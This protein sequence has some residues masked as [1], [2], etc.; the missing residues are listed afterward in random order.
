[1]TLKTTQIIRW[2]ILVS[3]LYTSFCILTPFAYALDLEV[4]GAGDPAVNGC[5]L[6]EGGGYWQ[7][8]DLSYEI[9][10]VGGSY[11]TLNVYGAGGATP[12]QYYTTP[13]C[14]SS[15]GA[16]GTWTN[17]DGL[18]APPPTLSE[19]ICPA[20]PMPLGGATSTVDQAQQNMILL[21]FLF[22]ACMWFIIWLM[23]KH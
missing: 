14:S 2:S 10:N 1:M 5:Y 8:Q 18:S 6:D 22:V 9:N 11:C 16:V 3:V 19:T 13:G 20:P 17:A 12:P 23:R 4:S 7:K 15:A 21:S